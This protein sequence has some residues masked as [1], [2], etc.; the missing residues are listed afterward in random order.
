MLELKGTK[1]WATATSLFSRWELSLRLRFA[2]G[3]IWEI[4]GPF[5]DGRNWE[6]DLLLLDLESRIEG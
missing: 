1:K 3:L 2:I 5:F 6:R 4:K